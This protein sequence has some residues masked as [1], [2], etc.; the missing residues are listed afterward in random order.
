[1]TNGCFIFGV[2][3]GVF[4]GLILGIFLGEIRSLE[5]LRLDHDHLSSSNQQKR[6]KIRR[7]YTPWTI[8]AL[9]SSG[10]GWIILP[11]R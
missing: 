2:I 6:S 7:L 11:D 8:W 1:L 10:G 4:L 3:H 9:A 5:G